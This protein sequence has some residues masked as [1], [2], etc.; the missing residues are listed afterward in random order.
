MRGL[1][2]ASNQRQAN[3]AAQLFC[4][5]KEGLRLAQSHLPQVIDEVRFFDRFSSRE[6]AVLN[7]AENPAAALEIDRVA[8]LNTSGSASS[9]RG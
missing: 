1:R 2:D 8:P 6:K 5:M 9:R 4:A 7:A 3:A